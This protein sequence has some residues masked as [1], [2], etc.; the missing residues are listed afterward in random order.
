M[1]RDS[2]RAPRVS[3]PDLPRLARR[4]SPDRSRRGPGPG[5]DRGSLGNGGCRARAP[6]GVHR[7][8]GIRRPPR[9]DRRDAHRRRD[10]GPAGDRAASGSRAGGGVRVTGGRIGTLDLRGAELDERGAARHPH[11]LPLARAARRATTCWSSDCVIGALDL[12]QATPRRGSR[13][14]TPGPTR[15]TPRGLR[16]EHLDLRGL[17]AVSYHSILRG[18]PATRRDA[19]R[20]ARSS[21]LA[22]A[23][24]VALGIRDRRLSVSPA[25]VGCSQATSPHGAG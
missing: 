20:S 24:A 23:L 10:H 9:P 11:R 2:L 15:S 5:P 8:R 18:A 22:P 12:P 16:C 19:R 25:T 13:S 14:R 7:G 17:E 4:P 3:A 1:A 6:R 21:A